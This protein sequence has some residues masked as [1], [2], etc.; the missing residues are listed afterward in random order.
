MGFFYADEHIAFS[1][2]HGGDWDDIFEE[3]PYSE[4]NW[5]SPEELRLMASLVLCELRDDAYVSLYPVVRYSP[6]IDALDLDL[7]CPLTVHRVREL[8]LNTIHEGQSPFGPHHRLLGLHGKKY[9]VVPAE[10]YGFDRLLKF[11]NALSDASLV[12]FRGIYTLIKADMLRQHYEFNEEAILSLYIALDASFS[13]VKLHLEHKGTREPTAHDAAVWLHHHF[14][15]PFG[16]EAPKATEK[17]FETFYEER[18]M[19][20]HPASRYGDLPYAPIMHDDI[21]HLRRSLREIFAYLLLEE[22][23]ADF[24]ADVQEHLARYPNTTGS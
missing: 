12:F 11:W 3:A 22:H 21:P 20:M 18:V 13:L 15:A 10:R 17:Y 23:G 16:L 8:I 6:R 19:T 14:D 9:D 4:F 7:T 5:A 2:V 24:H 1:L